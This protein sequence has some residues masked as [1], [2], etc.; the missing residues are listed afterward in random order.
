MESITNPPINLGVSEKQKILSKFCIVQNIKVAVFSPSFCEITLFLGIRFRCLR[1]LASEDP[2]AFCPKMRRGESHER[3]HN[4]T[5]DMQTRQERRAC[6]LSQRAREAEPI[7]TTHMNPPQQTHRSCAIF[8][9][10]HSKL[11]SGLPPS[12]LPSSSYV[13]GE[14]KQQR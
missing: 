4:E 10:S 6:L 8:S 11:G 1:N 2:I 13:A 12:L 9:A 3:T 14:K 7:I 5:N